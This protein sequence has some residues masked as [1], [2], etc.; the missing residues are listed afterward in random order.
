MTDLATASVATAGGPAARR[1]AGLSRLGPTGMVTGLAATCT[2]APGDNLALHRLV[3]TAPVG[4]VLVCAVGGDAGHGY[5][6]E[7]LALDARNRGLAS[8][9]IDGA[10][11][12]ADAIEALGFPVF[13]RGLAPEPC[14]KETAPSVGEPVEVS[15]VAVAPGDVVVADR[16]AVLVVAGAEWP[17]VAA[18]SSAIEADE[19]E[20]RVSIAR[21]ERLADL[22]GLDLGGEP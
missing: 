17:S 8:L 19:E 22:L 2:C 12:D 7:L 1:I 15:G 9:V 16:D 14:T 18:R 5:F 10:V 13:H 6:G 20:L 4:A 21:G 11:R 3:A